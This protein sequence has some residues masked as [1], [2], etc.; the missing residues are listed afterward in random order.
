[1]SCSDAASLRGRV[2]LTEILLPR[3]IARQ[4]T[5]C[6]ICVRGSAAKLEKFELR[7]LSSMR[8]S[9]SII[10]LSESLASGRGQDRHLFRLL[11]VYIISIDIM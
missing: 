5:V 3:R 11:Y 7:H 6:L 2:L 1:M 9:N 8:F 10:P 4:G